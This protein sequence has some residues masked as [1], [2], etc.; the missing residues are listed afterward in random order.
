MKKGVGKIWKIL[1]ILV[2]IIFGIIPIAFISCMF[3]QEIYPKRWT[4]F[5]SY[6]QFV[7]VADWTYYDSFLPESAH[8]MRYYYYEGG[9]SDMSGYH[10]TFSE[11]DY[12]IKKQRLLERY[13][14]ISSVYI[15][16]GS[17]KLFMNREQMMEVKVDFMD[18]LLPEGTDDGQFY[19]VAYHFPKQSDG[20]YSYKAALCNDSTYEII[21]LSCR[22]CE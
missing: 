12:V 18:K 2:I 16:N 6:S 17:E 5:R 1:L 10:A 4:H 15:Y 8:D 21:E 7:K 3:F 20:I 11:E 22:I 13:K 19:F 14:E 9:F